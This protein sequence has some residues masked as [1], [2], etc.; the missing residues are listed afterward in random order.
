MAAGARF[1][2]VEE[3]NAC[4]PRLRQLIEDIHQVQQAVAAARPELWAVFQKAVN[5]GGRKQASE[6]FF[7]F[8]RLERA[9]NEIKTLGCVLKDIDSGLI[10]FLSK[11]EEREVYLCWRYGEDEI[12]YW[13][14]LHTGFAG[15]QPLAD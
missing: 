6:L 15:R 9:V 14:E 4:L 10:D 2:T 3:A 1:F 12:R 7:L 8:Q 13:H 11:R 5:N